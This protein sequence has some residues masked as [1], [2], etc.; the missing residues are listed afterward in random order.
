MNDLLSLPIAELAER[1]RS[2]QVSAL[3]ATR[4]SLEAIERA[5]ELNA[6]TN[7]DHSGA[8]AQAEALDARRARGEVLG[9]LAGVPIAVKDVLCTRGFPT[10][11]GSK[12]LTRA[13]GQGTHT[14]GAADASRGWRPP[15]NATVV[16][17]LL[18][19]DAVLVGKTNMDEFAMGSSNENSAFGVARNPWDVTRVPGGSSG[20]SAVAVAASLTPG[21]IG[22]DTGGSIRQ[23]AALCGSVGIKPTYGR[24]S[25]YGL[26]AFA[27]SLDQIGPFAA[28]VR[29]AARLLSVMSGV[30]PQDSTSADVPVPNY[31]AAC[32]R[33]PRGLR[34]GIPEEYFGSGLDPEVEA[35]VRSAIAALEAAGCELHPV[36]LPHTRYGIA[37]YYVLA[38][39]EASSNLARFDGVRFGLRVEPPGANLETLYGATRDAGFGSEVKRR[40]L[41]GT[42]VLSAGYYD[43]YYRRA[44][45][46]RTLIRRDFDEVFTNVDALVAPVSPTP[47]WKLGER[48]QDPLA[49]YL[50]DIYTLPASLAGIAALSVPCAPTRARGDRPSLPVGL[51]LM[52]PAFSE[53]KLLTLAAAWERVSPAAKL[54]A[55]YVPG[56]VADLRPESAA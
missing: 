11:A 45:K 29:S 46:V 50:A 17:K 37:T 16:E 30:D 8:L 25:R 21:S 28:D 51:Q 54:K 35:S 52:G 22:T 40:I 4:A 13:D 53:E 31:E 47:A 36:K 55:P 7:V 6:F 44:Q 42:Y 5:A 12:I 43:A 27:S 49:M 3:A 20:G 38:T 32:E 15:Y 19:A 23:P 39:A 9:A 24:V 1:V 10:T 48:V 2:G 41:L 34:L 14:A 56:Q 26:I 18:A 33:D